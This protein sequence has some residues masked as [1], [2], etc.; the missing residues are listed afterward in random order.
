[1]SS[2]PTR[3][4]ASFRQVRDTL[5]HSS[6]RKLTHV[7]EESWP[8]LLDEIP[9]ESVAVPSAIRLE[10]RDEVLCLQK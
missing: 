6:L 4:T 9:V 7:P 5:L 2:L 8:G 3:A 1:V 10:D